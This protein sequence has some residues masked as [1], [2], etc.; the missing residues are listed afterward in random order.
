MTL[1][2]SKLK[3][4]L[5][6]KFATA[7]DVWSRKARETSDPRKASEAHR[8]SEDGAVKRGQ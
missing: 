1:A 5:K 7:G 3:I 2:V 8:V 6:S 4:K